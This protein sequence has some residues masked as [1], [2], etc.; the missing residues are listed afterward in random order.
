MNHE[1]THDLQL[2]GNAIS[3]RNHMFRP[4]AEGLRVITL[5]ASRNTSIR[6]LNSV[7]QSG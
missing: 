4:D 1:M 7:A 2:T 5:L 3:N 6:N